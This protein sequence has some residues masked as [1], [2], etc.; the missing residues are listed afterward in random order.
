MRKRCQAAGAQIE[1]RAGQQVVTLHARA[2][3]SA[4]VVVDEIRG[5]ISAA[6]AGHDSDIVRDVLVEFSLE[7]VIVNAPGTQ[8]DGAAVERGPAVVIERI[9]AVIGPLVRIANIEFKVGI[10]LG[11]CCR[12]EHQSDY[13]QEKDSGHRRMPPWFFTVT[14]TEIY[15]YIDTTNPAGFP[16]F[17]GNCLF[18]NLSAAVRHSKNYATS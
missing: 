5:V 4:R 17:F 9:G 10:I 2:E 11:E 18:S 1:A 13:E 7:S 3:R 8:I 12:R 14:Q 16:D 6:E 15:G